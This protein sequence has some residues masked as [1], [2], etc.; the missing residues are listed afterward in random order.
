MQLV[1]FDCERKDVS[2]LGSINE[3]INNAIFKYKF[4]SI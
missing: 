3:K 2:L 1:N 4:L